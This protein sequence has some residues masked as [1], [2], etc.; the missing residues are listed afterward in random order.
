M[1]IKYEPENRNLS[2]RIEVYRLSVWAFEFPF[3]TRHTQSHTV[4]HT[5]TLKLIDTLKLDI[6]M[7]PA[8]KTQLIVTTKIGQKEAS[9]SQSQS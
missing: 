6:S 4:M 7:A 8:T 2:Q 1:V 5:H 9:Q 3:N